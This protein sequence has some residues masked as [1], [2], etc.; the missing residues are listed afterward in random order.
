MSNPRQAINLPKDVE[1]YVEEGKDQGLTEDVAWPV[2]WSR[3]CKKNPGSDHCHKSK[4]EY[5]PGRKAED[6][7]LAKRVAQRY[8]TLQSN[9]VVGSPIRQRINSELI[10]EGMD[11]NTRFKS[12]G[13]ALAKINSVLQKFKIEWDEVIDSWRLKQSKGQMMVTLATQ[14]ADP[15]S[16]VSIEN[17]ALS[18]HWDTLESGIEVIA[19]LG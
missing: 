13:M 16:P 8:A 15:F 7:S 18:F 1:R 14:T 19:Y 10:R 11:G 17:T 2:A 5:F 4:D 6:V 9:S 12:P 3:Y